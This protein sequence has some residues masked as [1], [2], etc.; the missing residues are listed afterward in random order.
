M[1]V[2]V[3]VLVV[4]VVVIVVV[5]VPFMAIQDYLLCVVAVA[6]QLGSW[7]GYVLQAALGR[8]DAAPPMASSS[9]WR[10]IRQSV[11]YTSLWRRLGHGG[12]LVHPCRPGPPGSALTRS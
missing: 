10:I 4:V 1:V 8:R 12:G 7:R 11:V 5:V 6:D 3:V 9:F 2:V